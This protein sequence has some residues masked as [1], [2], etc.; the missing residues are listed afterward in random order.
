MSFDGWVSGVIL[1]ATDSCA[2]VFAGYGG[3]RSTSPSW[4]RC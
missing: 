2:A 4:W 1:D 3:M